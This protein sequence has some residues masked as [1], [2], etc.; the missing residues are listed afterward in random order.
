MDNLNAEIQH[1]FHELNSRYAIPRKKAIERLATI[2]TPAVIGLI[3]TLNYGNPVAQ[4]AAAEALQRIGTRVAKAAAEHW[5][6]DH[7]G[8]GV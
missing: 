3:Q 1:L 5:L 6:R 2:G 8:A 4:E 7:R